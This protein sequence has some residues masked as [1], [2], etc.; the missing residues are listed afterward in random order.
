MNKYSI[1]AGRNTPTL[2]EPSSNK[3]LNWNLA[4]T[5]LNI[6]MFE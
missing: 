2:L 5:K 4:L 1:A 3:P 6:L